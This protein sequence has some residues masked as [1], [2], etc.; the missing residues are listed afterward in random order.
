MEGHR[1]NKSASASGQVTMIA[2]GLQYDSLLA[3]HFT[4]LV[5]LMNQL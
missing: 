3:V 1:N 2:L 4:Q 5:E